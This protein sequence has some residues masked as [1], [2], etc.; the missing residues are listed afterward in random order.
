MAEAAQISTLPVTS[1]AAN[2]INAEAIARESCAIV[3]ADDFYPKKHLISAEYL[4]KMR[5]RAQLR[6]ALAG[7]RLATLLNQTLGKQ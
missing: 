2:E 5:P 3:Q 4:S 7:R 1:G 6:V